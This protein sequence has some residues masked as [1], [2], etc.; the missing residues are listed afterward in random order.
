MIKNNLQHSPCEIWRLVSGDGVVICSSV[1]V[2]GGVIERA[3]CN[4][5]VFLDSETHTHTHTHEAWT[6]P[7][8][9]WCPK[10]YTSK[11]STTLT[12]RDMM[13]VSF[14]RCICILFVLVHHVFLPAA[15][16]GLG[17]ELEVSFLETCF[18]MFHSQQSVVVS[19][20]CSSFLS[21]LW[22]TH[23]TWTQLSLWHQ[24]VTYHQWQLTISIHN[25][26]HTRCLDGFS[27]SVKLYFFHLMDEV[28]LSAHTA[29]GWAFV[30]TFL[31]CLLYTSP[32][33]RD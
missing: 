14:L 21:R 29:V 27:S 31:T 15:P 32:S 12:M 26:H 33:P 18:G 19:S 11:F 7:L 9:L 16:F 30:D 5:F 22:D 20:I 23:E 10:E 8:S 6:P 24:C 3:S 2:L 1:F 28:F 25:T 17:K 13:A 4:L